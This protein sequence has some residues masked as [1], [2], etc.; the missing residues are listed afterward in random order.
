M[1][2]VRIAGRG[3]GGR[4]EHRRGVADGAGEHVLVGESGPQYSPKSGPRLLRAR[5]GLRPDEP[6]RA[7]GD[8]D[9]A[10]HV[11]AV[12]D[13]DHPR[14][15]RRGR[16]PLEPP[17]E[18]SRFHGL[19]VGPYASGSVVGD[20]ASSGRLVLPRMHEPGGAV[21]LH[22]HGVGGRRRTAASFSTCIP[23]WYG[24]PGGVG[25]AVLE[26]ERHAA[27]RAVGERTARRRARALSNI[28]VITAFSDGFRASMRAI[29]ASTSSAGVTS[30]A[31]AR[32]RPGRS[33]RA[34]ARRWS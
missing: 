28:G 33:R 1:G 7:R 4:V 6:A 34:T 22:Q 18:W 32:G 11:V 31:I 14:R 5:V 27:E 21:A 12:G 9:R 26:Q 25:D 23:Q 30:P 10:A 17:G 20:D 24:S 3:P 8:P 2:G 29:A 16:P 15:D 19:R 13:R